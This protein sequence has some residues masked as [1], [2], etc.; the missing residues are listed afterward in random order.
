MKNATGRRL[1]Y[2]EAFSNAFP[3]GKQHRLEM[4][5]DSLPNCLAAQLDVT[6]IVFAAAFSRDANNK[7][8]FWMMGGLEIE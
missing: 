4:A 2:A 1:R 5:F 8:F 3:A 7:N 6:I